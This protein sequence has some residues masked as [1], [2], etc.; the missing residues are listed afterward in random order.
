MTPIQVAQIVAALGNDGVVY[1][2]QLIEQIV[3]PTG[4]PIYQFQPEQVGSLPVST[5][6]LESIQR[7]MISVVE[8]PRGTAQF[9]LGGLSRNYYP[10]AGKT[11][12]AESGSGE[13]HAWFTGY[14]M[15][16]NPNYPDIAIVVV[17]E[18]A[19]EGSEIAAPI[20][21]A[22]IQQ[23]FT[24]SRTALPWESQIG[25]LDVEEEEEETGEETP[26]EEGDQDE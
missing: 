3:P 22:M 25:V 20:F 24:G 16:N 8:N 5:E 26:T 15:D 10:M 18:N 12:T 17:A 21:R 19:G 23:Y 4:E 7:A 6:T 1:R 13:P 14:T 2:P 11:G 9:I